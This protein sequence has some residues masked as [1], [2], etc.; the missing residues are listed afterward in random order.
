MVEPFY[1]FK[2]NPDPTIVNLLA[3]LGCGFDCATQG[4]LKTVL[5]E[6]GSDLSFSEKKGEESRNFLPLNSDKIVYANPA[7]M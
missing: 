2:S 6:L 7:K 1:A 3:T 4:E 5:H